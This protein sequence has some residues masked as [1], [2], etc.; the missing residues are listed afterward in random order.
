MNKSKDFLVPSNRTIK[1]SDYDPDDTG[2][3]RSKS[4]ANEILAKHQQRLF[5]LQELLYAD[6]SHALLVVLQG[7]DAGGKDGTIRHIFTGVNPQGCQVTSFKEPT[8]EELRHDFLWRIHRAV[9]AHGM[10]GIFNRSHYEDVL[11]VRVHGSL[12]K[13]E[14]AR[15]FD[16]INAFEKML[17]RNGVVILKFF[18]HISK[19]EQRDRLQTRLDDPTK[20]WK[21]SPSDMKERMYWDKYV[22]A[23]E[24]VFSHSSSESAPWYII[25]A[26][27]KWYRNV[28]ISQILVDTLT[29]LKLKYPKPK[30]DIPGLELK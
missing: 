9:P 3:L 6:A 28:R 4:H 20:F 17:V 8:P 23:Y 14:L 27:K 22:E 24:D 1:L 19:G 5:E 11:V 25:P 21:A 10:I 15:R 7:L 18:L 12:S 29:G 16:E 30:S 2:R 26:N 13:K